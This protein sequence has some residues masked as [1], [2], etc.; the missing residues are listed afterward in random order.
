MGPANCKEPTEPALLSCSH[1][2]RLQCARVPASRQP[3]L[4]PQKPPRR[5]GDRAWRGSR[6][7]E[8]A[9]PP[10]AAARWGRGRSGPVPTRLARQGLSHLTRENQRGWRGAPGRHPPPERPG[11]AAVFLPAQAAVTGVSALWT[12][13]RAP[14]RAPRDFPPRPH[15]LCSAPFRPPWSFPKLRLPHG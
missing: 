2:R 14:H 6:A 15:P 4:P 13:P 9:A 8:G 1:S 12:S 10:A 11:C 7:R 3:F 5:G